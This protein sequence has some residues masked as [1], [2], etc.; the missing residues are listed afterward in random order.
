M[1]YRSVGSNACMEDE[2]GYGVMNRGVRVMKYKKKRVVVVNEMDIERGRHGRRLERGYLLATYDKA[3]GCWNLDSSNIIRA[4]I[5][6][7]PKIKEVRSLNFMQATHRYCLYTM[8][9]SSI[10]ILI[11]LFY[12]SWDPIT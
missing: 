7:N 1:L 10:G 2:W 9:P 3:I 8:F 12:A 4:E 6:S 5:P 11:T